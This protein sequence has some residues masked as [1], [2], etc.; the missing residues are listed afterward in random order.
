MSTAEIIREIQS[1]PRR[2]RAR[3]I[4]FVRQLEDGE[5]PASFKKS[6]ADIEAGRVVDLDTALTKPPPPQR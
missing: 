2:E 3:V 6:V 4:E 1:L 5:I